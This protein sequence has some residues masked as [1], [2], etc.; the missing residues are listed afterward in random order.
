[1]CRHKISEAAVWDVY[2]LMNKKSLIKL[3]LCYAIWGTAALYW[4]LFPEF[5]LVFKVA[6]RVVFSALFGI[7]CLALTKNLHVLKEAFLDRKRIKYIV[8]SSLCIG[9][10]W[11]VYVWA[12]SNGHVV[13]ASLANYMNPIAIS[14]FSI[15]I[16]K[17]KADAL[18]IASM[19][20]ALV[21]VMISVIAYG[22][23]PYVGILVMASFTA[24]TLFKKKARTEGLVATTLETGLL[25][26]LALAYMLI[27]GM[28]E[29]GF[30]SVH[31]V[32][33][34]LL[35]L[36]TGVYTATPFIFY[37]S[38]VN[39]FSALF[40][41]LSGMFTPTLTLLTGVLFLGEKIT[42]VTLIN[43]ICILIAITL[44]VWS[45]VRKN[46]FVQAQ[47]RKASTSN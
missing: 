39:N 4:N 46:R 38:G 33:T 34:A 47:N 23:F 42:T 44:F 29:G 15:F 22:S 20:I 27:F 24:Y 7:M 5:G 6:C 32:W 43:L 30:G 21:G 17:D 41:G 14:V 1:M 2:I 10:N 16:F 40:V 9:A 13:D 19:C 36:S 11:L 12:L 35:L 28:G 37:A 18:Q 45:M 8:L 25:T 26:P 31:S 3:S